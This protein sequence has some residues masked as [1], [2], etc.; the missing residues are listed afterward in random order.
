M[1][2]LLFAYPA[3]ETFEAWSKETGINAEAIITDHLKTMATDGIC[4]VEMADS[5]SGSCLNL[6]ISNPAWGRALFCKLG[7]DGNL[8][9]NFIP[10]H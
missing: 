8:S 6:K 5:L 2:T 4:T 9:A 1:V 3:R 10:F 7:N